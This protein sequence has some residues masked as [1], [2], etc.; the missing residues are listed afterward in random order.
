VVSRQTRD[1]GIRLALG[2]SESHIAQVIARRGLLLLISGLILGLLG[3]YALTRIFAT[4]L[5]GVSSSDIF[6]FAG[7]TIL[8]ALVAMAAMVVPV[9]M[10]IR[11][12]PVSAIRN[13]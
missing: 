6:T 10:A 4:L 2:V 1:I 12:D 11:L 3:A 7:A 5:F 9:R 13:E 8:L